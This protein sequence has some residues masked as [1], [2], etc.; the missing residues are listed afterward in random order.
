MLRGSMERFLKKLLAIIVMLM[1]LVLLGLFI[2]TFREGIFGVL[3]FL[4][5]LFKELFLSDVIGKLFIMVFIL[6]IGSTLCITRRNERKLWGILTGIFTVV[7]G[8]LMF[9]VI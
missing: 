7:S 9:V 8:L 3:Y 4:W 5:Q 2:P 6:I 1:I